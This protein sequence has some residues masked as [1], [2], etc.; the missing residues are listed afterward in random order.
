MRKKRPRRLVIHGRIAGD[1]VAALCDRVREQ[2][3]ATAPEPLV[4]DVHG[5]TDVD[6]ETVGGLARLQLAARRSGG[7]IRLR[8]P[9]RALRELLA[10][11]GLRDVVRCA[12]P[13]RRAAAGARTPGRSARCRGRT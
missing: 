6:L 12:A 8:R 4:C 11:T 13:T 1:D 2:V 10:L 9:S 7:E 5:V 3:A